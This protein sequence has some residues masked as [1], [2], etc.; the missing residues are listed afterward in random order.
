[1]VGVDVM[2]TS[3]SMPE[4]KAGAGVPEV[5]KWNKV[6]IILQGSQI[7]TQCHN[8]RVNRTNCIPMG[9]PHPSQLVGGLVGVEKRR[10]R[11]IECDGARR[12]LEDSSSV[13]GG[14]GGHSAHIATEETDG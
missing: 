5:Q 4:K 10:N 2:P 9:C 1:M 13:Q 11:W 3:L 8:L 14:L 12:N 6:P 7:G